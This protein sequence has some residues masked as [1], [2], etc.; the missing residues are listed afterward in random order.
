[1]KRAND[2]R[3]QY[4]L[5]MDEE[6]ILL[7][8]SQILERRLQRQGAI[9]D[10]SDAADFLKARCA[11]LPHEVFGV[12]FL[13]TRHRIIATEHLF[14]GTI[15]GCEVHP[16]IVAKQALDHNR[17]GH[18]LSQPSQRKP[19]AQRGRPCPD[20]PPEAVAGTAG[21]SSAGPSGGCGNLTRVDGLTGVGVTT[22]F[23]TQERP[24]AATGRCATGDLK[25]PRWK[26]DSDAFGTHSMLGIFA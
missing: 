4:Q 22:P 5:T 13:D 2:I 18:L 24:V 3:A 17:G 7:A 23:L 11:G 12:V 19:G 1:M 20:G 6:G 9:T 26:K 14:Q 21:R 15:D 16:R 10:P 25:N 8:A